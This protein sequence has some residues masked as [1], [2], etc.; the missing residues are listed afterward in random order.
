MVENGVLYY[1]A[2]N[3]SDW[4][5]SEVSGAGIKVTK[6]E[7]EMEINISKDSRGRNSKEFIK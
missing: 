2:S 7:N 4:G 5:W 3:D 6:T 1:H